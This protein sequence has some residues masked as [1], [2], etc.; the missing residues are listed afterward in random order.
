ML[1]IRRSLARQGFKDYISRKL[2]AA[3]PIYDFPS[4][5]VSSS[6]YS[7]R[8]NAIRPYNNMIA[9]MVGA[10]RVRPKSPLD[11]STKL[12]CTQIIPILLP[13]TQK[14]EEPVILSSVKVGTLIGPYHRGQLMAGYT[15]SQILSVIYLLTK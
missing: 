14:P 10:H 2:S 15:R 7:K 13:F 4:P 11:I 3:S 1:I 9:P 5:M 6:S 8:A 12:R